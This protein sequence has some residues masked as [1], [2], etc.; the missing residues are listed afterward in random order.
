MRTFARFL[1]NVYQ[2]NV[3]EQF[4]KFFEDPMNNWEVKA[5]KQTDLPEEQ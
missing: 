4:D 5:T 1:S 3:E 2:Y